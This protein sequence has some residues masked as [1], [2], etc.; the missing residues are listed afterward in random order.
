M[1]LPFRL[2]SEYFWLVCLGVTWLNSRRADKELVLLGGLSDARLHEARVYIRLFAV[3]GGLPWIVVGFGQVLGF[4]LS[5]TVLIKTWH[6]LNLFK[7]EVRLDGR[8]EGV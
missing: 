1:S 8:L 2:I 7:Q 6:Y 5:L 3:L 4:T